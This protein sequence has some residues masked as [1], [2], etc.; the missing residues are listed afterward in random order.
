M[1]APETTAVNILRA[2]HHLDPPEDL[3]GV[4]GSRLYDRIT[5]D[6]LSEL[7]EILGAARATTGPILELASGSG[8]ITRALPALG[9]ALTAV[10]S[11]PEMLAMLK[12][13]SGARSFN[14]RG[15]HLEIVCADMSKL[16][17]LGTFGCIVLGAS[18][19]TLLDG[20][21]RKGL[22]RR[23]RDC[24]APDGRF[25]LTVLDPLP[26]VGTTR[27]EAAFS[28]FD[29]SSILFTV[30]RREP[31]RGT[32]K[33]TII[34]VDFEEA[35]AYRSAAY[36]SDIAYVGN[37]VVRA[38]LAAEGLHILERRPVRISSPS[39]ALGGVELWV[40]GT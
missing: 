29:G 30:E 10:D 33:V 39:P 4:A 32:R 20:E 7:P 24:L 5:A 38:E 19:V 28:V 37:D 35:G 13:R 21:R 22:F 3:Y 15:T 31:A 6:D 26:G 18:S 8:R 14:P 9:R 23:V 36:T 25:V 17:F 2:I 34:R 12:E 27:H 40:C 11:S 1:T 16:D